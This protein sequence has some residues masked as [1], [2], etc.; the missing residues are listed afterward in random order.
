MYIYEQFENAEQL[1]GVLAKRSRVVTET[2][3]ITIFVRRV[4]LE[5]L[6]R[7]VYSATTKGLLSG[8]G[9]S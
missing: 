9:A 2:D 3:I 7:T 1:K 5:L 4:E 8:S 6:A